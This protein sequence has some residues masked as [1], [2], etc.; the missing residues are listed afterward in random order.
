MKKILTLLLVACTFL[1]GCSNSEYTSTKLLMDTVCTITTD[2]ELHAINAFAKIE[3]IAEETDYFSDSSY[4]AKINAAKANQP[5]AL[6]D[7][8]FEMIKTALEVYEASDGAFDITT[9]PLKDVW[10]F[11][12][13]DH[14][15]PTS[16]QI[17]SALNITTSDFISLDEEKKT[18]VKAYD[19]IKIDLGA[20]AKGYAADI[21][22]KSLK[23][24]GASYGLIN[25]GGTVFV[26]G[27]NPNREDGKWEIGIANPDGEGYIT[28]VTIEKGAVVT[29]GNYQRY[30]EWGGKRYHHIINP[31]DGY[32]ADNG[33]SSA[34]IIGD[35]ALIADCLSTACMIVNQEDASALAERFGTEFIG[36]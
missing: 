9:A 8:V 19:A 21:A 33:L 6:S 28:T 10:G 30:F 22:A 15:P 12:Q 24:S 35:S 23:N 7:S 2:S 34:T 25:L 20:V 5:I 1:S 27:K 36:F 4:V 31:K 14:Q 17:R 13:G 26:F 29:S 16:E 3:E 11:N 32:P 18:I